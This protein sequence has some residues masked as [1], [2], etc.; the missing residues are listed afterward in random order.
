MIGIK[1][2]P[3]DWYLTKGNTQNAID[4]LFSR[5]KVSRKFDVPDLAGYA[6]NGKDFF[7]DKDCPEFLEYA[8]RKIEVD[9]FLV[10]HEEVELALIKLLHLVYQDCHQVACL[11][12]KE[13]VEMVCGMGCWEPYSE[14][15]RKQIDM[16][17][18]KKNPQ[19]PP[20]LFKKPY[21]DEKEHAKLKQMGYMK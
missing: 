17:W 13:A 1:H 7:I 2:G 21:V 11:A 8:G 9:K 14:F 12:E 15:M 3:K 10:L 4:A 6:E 19:A 18:N 20:N 16:A 5:A